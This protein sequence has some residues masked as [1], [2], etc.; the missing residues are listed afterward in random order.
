MYLSIV[1][2]SV[3]SQYYG[4]D[5]SDE[6]EEQSSYT[7]EG[8]DRPDYSKYFKND[9]SAPLISGISEEVKEGNQ[10]FVSP[11]DFSSFFGSSQFGNNIQ[12]NH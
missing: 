8:D 11:L 5:Y 3:N 4:G 9:G 7:N 12:N 10:G 2:I 6:G 1:I